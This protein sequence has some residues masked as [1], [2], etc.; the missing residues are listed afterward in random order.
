MAASR[1]RRTL[2]DSSRLLL[3][4]HARHARRQSGDIL[5]DVNSVERSNAIS[6]T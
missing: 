6:G 1:L 3:N 5:I 2:E 4:I